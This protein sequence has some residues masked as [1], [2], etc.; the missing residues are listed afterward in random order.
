MARAKA[1]TTGNIL[2]GW[3]GAGLLPLSPISVLERLRAKTTPVA[4]LPHTLPQQHDLD[5]LLLDSSL[6]DGTQLREA[7]ALLNSAIKAVE[8]PPLQVR[9]YGMDDSLHRT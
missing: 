8:G 5:F 6:P 9:I 2:A 3:R 1:I 7:R 4:L